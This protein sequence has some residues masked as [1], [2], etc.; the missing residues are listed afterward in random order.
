MNT[1]VISRFIPCLGLLWLWTAFFCRV[2][3]WWNE[4]SYYTYG[5]AVP[6]F[7]GLLWFRRARVLEDHGEKE[8]DAGSARGVLPSLGLLIAYVPLRLIAEPDP[9]WRFPLWLEATVLVCLTLFSIDR[10]YG[11][12]SA[13]A[14][15]I[16]CMFL[17]TALP[18]PA[19]LETWLV[20]GLTNLVTLATAEG[21]LWLGHPAE[22]LGHSIRIGEETV[23]INNACSGIRSFQ[24][25]LAV[26]LFLFAYL[27]LGFS[28]GLATVVFSVFA[29]LFFNL[30]RAMAL[31]LIYLLGTDATY[32]SWHDPVGYFFITA[33]FV[34]LALFARALGKKPTK[35]PEISESVHQGTHLLVNPG[36]ACLLALSCL[37]PEVVS[38]SWFRW[39]AP[40][41]DVPGWHVEW[42]AKSKPISEGVADVLLFDYGSLG[43]IDLP[44]GRLAEIIH[45]G[46][47]GSS[48]AASICSRNHDPATCMGHYGTRLHDDRQEVLCKVDNARLRFRHY[49]AGD[50]NSEGHHPMHVWWCPWVR[51]SRS[52]AFEDKGGSPVAKARRFLSGKVSFERKVLLVILRGHASTEQAEGELTA[53]LASL[54]RSG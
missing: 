6:L 13:R 14:A 25:L 30:G 2:H 41:K 37:L 24:G 18:W 47:D 19:V 4:A 1:V 12:S 35:K 38:Y 9:F 10:L 36:V 48:P 54:V 44:G 49:I 28:A 7:C 42:P 40:A 5:W 34:T 23:L 43:N 27:G 39:V 17:F 21:L 31:S 20:Q 51:D 3:L 32:K 8:P 45:F 53:V 16:P 29:S 52:G 15:L 46:Y 50:P 22:A 33:A 26:S 11:R